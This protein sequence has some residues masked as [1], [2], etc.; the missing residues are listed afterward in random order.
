MNFAISYSGQPKLVD[1]F[2]DFPSFCLIPVIPKNLNEPYKVVS[3][4]SYILSSIILKDTTLVEVLP[5]QQTNGYTTC[6]DGNVKF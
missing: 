5:K 2:P 6:N 4:P 1:Y 3:L